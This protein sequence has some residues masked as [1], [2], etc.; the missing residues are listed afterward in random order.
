M[1]SFLLRDANKKKRYPINKY[2]LDIL[3]INS[4]LYIFMVTL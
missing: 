2:I 3:E 1:T 4:Q